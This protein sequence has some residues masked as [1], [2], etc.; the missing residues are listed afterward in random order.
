MERKCRSSNMELLRIISMYMIVFIHANMYLNQFC[1]GLPWLLTNGLVNGICNIGVTCF[2]LISGYYGMNFQIKKLIKLECM[3]ISY[4]ILETL[5]LLLLYPEQ[6]QGAV[7][8]EALIKS[9][10]P[11]ITRKYWF[12]SCYV[13]LYLFSGFINNVIRQISQK[14]FRNLLLL[15]LT[16]F[17]LLPTIFYF[18]IIPDNGKGFVQ[19]TMIYLIGRY[20]KLYKDISLPKGKSICIFCLLWIVNGISHEIPLEFGGIFHHLCKDNSITNIIMAILL[21]YLFK[22]ISFHSPLLN[23][24]ASGLFAAFA[25]NNSLVTLVMELL[26]RSSLSVSAGPAG[27]F[28]LAGLVFIILTA[29]ISLGLLREFL[30]HKADDRLAEWGMKV[31]SFL[32]K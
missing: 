4:S 21:V 6:M 5:L 15:S 7:L 31:Y 29:C 19:M 14:D 13:C 18:Q 12:Y 9:C 17:S 27:P 3:M 22:E 8:M 20:I 16:L 28:I 24:A 32:P 26:N 10:F 1:S 11:V 25:L 30:C 23:K 2:I